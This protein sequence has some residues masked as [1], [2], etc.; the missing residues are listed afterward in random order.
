M[1]TVK[2]PTRREFR[3]ALGLT[4]ALLFFIVLLNVALGTPRSFDFTAFYAGGKIILQGNASKLYDLGEQTRIERQ[5]FEGGSLLVNPHPPFEALWFA[6][7]ASL[8][9]LEAYMLWGAFN[10][11]FWL[12]FQ[13]FLR[14]YAPIPAQ[15][16]R[17][18]ML[19]S[20]FFPLWVALMRG[21]TSVLL[22][23]LFSLTY[24]FLERRRDFTAGVFLGLGLF[25][26]A[27]VVPFA[28]I[29]LL[30]SRW[31]LMAG[32]TA[33]A[34]LLA[35]LSLIA[36]GP[37]GIRSYLDL[38]VATTRDPDNPVYRDSFRAW[39]MPTLG[40]LFAAMLAGRLSA[41]S[42]GVLAAAVSACLI[43][44]VAWRWRQE[45]QCPGE[46]SH[47]LMFAAA[48]VI[49]QV[50][51]PH[52]YTHDLTL[53]LLAILLVI[54]SPQ[55]TEAA[56]L[57]KVLLATIVILYAP[58][59][60]LLLMHWQ[61]VYLLAPVLVAFAFATISLARVDESGNLINNTRENA[62]GPRENAP[63]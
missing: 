4:A 14:P 42:I 23:L 13:R 54:G 56:A 33:A 38:L 15:P 11:L 17:Y 16:F 61:A 22:L 55:W 28:V 30:R 37:S 6:P 18:L 62:L 12:L 41:A 24:V 45:D 46:K 26:F 52:L 3:I 1:S 9:Y 36:V 57:R 50:A 44:F 47:G 19:C 27:I 25:K 43:F 39:G 21:Q 32:L 59:A 51:A 48:L 5:V 8:P 63:C 60:Y 10:V 7:L 35:V 2:T 29:C 31:R 53:M 58:P 49:A 34:S 20:L 40:G